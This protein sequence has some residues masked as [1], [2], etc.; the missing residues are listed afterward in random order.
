MSKH[1]IYNV[2]VRHEWNLLLFGIDRTFTIKQEFPIP[3]SIDDAAFEVKLKYARK[4]K[5]WLRFGRFTPL[6]LQAMV[7][8]NGKLVP[9]YE[10][11]DLQQHRVT[12]NPVNTKNK[13]K[14]G[15]GTSKKSRSRG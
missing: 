3:L 12:V 14:H 7:V 9:M 1:S 13:K 10:P 6:T 5:N 11:V 2:T 8:A 4:N 15:L